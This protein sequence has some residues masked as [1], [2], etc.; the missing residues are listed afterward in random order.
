MTDK[1]ILDE[2]YSKLNSWKDETRGASE[3]NG[4]RIIHDRVNS[5]TAFIEEEWQK[6]DEEEKDRPDLEQITEP[7]VSPCLRPTSTW[8]IDAREMERHREL[9]IGEDGT[10]KELK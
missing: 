1:E 9:E 4:R 2:V 8:C 7:D 5:V 10:V 3:G 6:Q